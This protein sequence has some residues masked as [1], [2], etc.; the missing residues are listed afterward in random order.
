ME[1]KE[2]EKIKVGSLDFNYLSMPLTPPAHHEWDNEL[3]RQKE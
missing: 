1:K 2:K 3:R